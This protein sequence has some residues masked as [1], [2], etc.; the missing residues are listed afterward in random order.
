MGYCTKQEVIYALANALTSG[1]PTSAP[2]VVSIT[3]IGNSITSTVPTSELLQYIRWA[4]QEIDGVLSSIYRVP[5]TRINQGSFPLALD[6][7]TADTYVIVNDATIFTEDDIVL[8]RDS[9]NFQEMQVAAYTTATKLSFT[10]PLTSG[11]SSLDT[12]IEL[13][14]YPEP[15]PLVSA[16]LA[17]AHLYDHH[18][19]AQ[20]EGNESNFG[21]EL[22][23]N[24]HN[25]LNLI[26]G[27]AIMLKIPDANNFVGR[28]FANGSLYDVMSTRAEPGKKW[29]EDGG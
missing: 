29:I 1:V 24:A 13:I 19:A 23:K 3:S 9:V 12:R 22:R 18:Y 14:K 8:I 6:A 10:T 17:A 15:I 7:L 20:A 26:L 2:S 21:K 25:T 11:Y 27:G 16:K 4:D 28:R 5:L